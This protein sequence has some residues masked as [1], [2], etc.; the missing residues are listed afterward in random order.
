M[1][2]LVCD[3]NQETCRRL[4]DTILAYASGKDIVIGVG[5][6]YSEDALRSILPKEA[7]RTFC[8]WRQGSVARKKMG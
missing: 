7:P 5:V 3:S 6:F 1:E 2:I 8:F 4:E